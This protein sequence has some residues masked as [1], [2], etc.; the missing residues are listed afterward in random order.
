[1]PPVPGAER[2]LDV[3][4]PPPDL[5]AVADRLL[6]DAWV[7]PSLDSL[8]H[9]FT[10]IAVTRT[11]RVLFASTGELRQ[12]AAG[13]GERVLEERNRRERLMAASER[14]AAQEAGAHQAVEQAR[15]SVLSAYS[16]RDSAEGAL[17]GAVRAAEEA[18]EEVRR[19]EWLIER[20]GQAPDEGPSAVATPTNPCSPRVNV[21]VIVFFCVHANDAGGNSI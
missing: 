4:T 11:G 12:V 14:A 16:G 7:V 8:P 1:M 6:A 21:P 20:R 18:A 13:S 5:R 10:G 3:V 15:E 19:I 17:R 9:G 2:L